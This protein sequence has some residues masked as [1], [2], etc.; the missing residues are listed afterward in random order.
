MCWNWVVSDPTCGDYSYESRQK[1]EGQP[2]PPPLS[3]SHKPWKPTWVHSHSAFS[4]DLLQLPKGLLNVV[5]K[6]LKRILFTVS[7]K[8]VPIYFCIS[9]WKCTF[10][11]GVFVCVPVCVCV[12]DTELISVQVVGL[13]VSKWISYRWRRSR[14]PYV[15]T[16]WKT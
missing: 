10:S 8:N 11:C 4:T 13:A 1:L 16:S 12:C 14:W 5:E 9:N 6:L 2:L 15:F 3:P 7:K